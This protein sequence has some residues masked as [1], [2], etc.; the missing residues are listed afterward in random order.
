MAAANA[1]G[2]KRLYTPHPPVTIS[3]GVGLS[4]K[5]IGVLDG[6][7]VLAREPGEDDVRYWKLVVRDGILVGAVLLGD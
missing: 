4:V 7:E 5:S 3:K 6:D 2:A 1:V